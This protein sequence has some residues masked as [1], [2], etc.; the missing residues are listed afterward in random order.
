MPTTKEVVVSSSGDFLG[1]EIY[2]SPAEPKVEEAFVRPAYPLSL[3]TA[4]MLAWTEQEE[5]VECSELPQGKLKV[6]GAVPSSLKVDFE[7]GVQLSVE[8][9]VPREFKEGRRPGVTR[10]YF[11]SVS[12]S[13]YTVQLGSP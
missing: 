3:G 6:V 4:G 10:N 13:P 7:P 1:Y 2:I 9:I 11:F 5:V 8:D 12:A